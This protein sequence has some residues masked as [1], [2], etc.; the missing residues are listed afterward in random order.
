M[1]E[2]RTRLLADILRLINHMEHNQLVQAHAV[3]QRLG[4]IFE[5]T[6]VKDCNNQ[7]KAEDHKYWNL[8]KSNNVVKSM[9]LSGTPEKGLPFAKKMLEQI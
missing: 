5:E 8:L 9:I 3:A 1:D 2:N 4:A 7:S 6:M